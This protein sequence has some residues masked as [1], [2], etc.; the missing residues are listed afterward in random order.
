MSLYDYDILTL[1]FF[2]IS[3]N[4]TYYI[5]SLSI[6]FA[7]DIIVKRNLMNIYNRILKLYNVISPRIVHPKTIHSFQINYV[8]VDNRSDC[9][10][11]HLNTFTI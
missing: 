1:V 10:I 9:V 4:S 11:E 8:Y 3:L 7:N 6:R 2:L 5:L